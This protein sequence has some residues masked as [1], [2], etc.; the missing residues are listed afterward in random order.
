MLLGS[1]QKV[2]TGYVAPVIPVPGVARVIVIRETG[3]IIIEAERTERKVL[4]QL[5]VKTAAHEHREMCGASGLDPDRDRGCWS[6]G[7]RSDNRSAHLDGADCD[8]RA[9]AGAA[10]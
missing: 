7:D 2:E 3:Q 5:D 6:H 1:E 10:K 8:T 4:A 9:A